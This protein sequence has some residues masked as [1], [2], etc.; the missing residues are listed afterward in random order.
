MGLTVKCRSV[1]DMETNMK[2]V[3]AVKQ[4]RQLISLRKCEVMR[5]LF[6]VSIVSKYLY[7]GGRLRRKQD[8][9]L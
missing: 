7:E 9:V 5:V 6:L 4:V 2:L 1:H 8:K 3:P